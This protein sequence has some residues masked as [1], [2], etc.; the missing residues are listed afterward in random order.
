MVRNVVYVYI[1][2][3]WSRNRC[4]SEDGMR[5]VVVRMHVRVVR[6]KVCGVNVVKSCVKLCGIV[7]RSV[8]FCGILWDCVGML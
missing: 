1:Y 6:M 2:M 8:K 4:A 3:V 7:W 5:M